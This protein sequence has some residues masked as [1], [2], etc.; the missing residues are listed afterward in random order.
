MIGAALYFVSG[1]IDWKDAQEGVDWGL[2]IF[3]G[4]ALSLGAALL[5]TGAANYII[6]HLIGMMGGKC[7]NTC[8]YALVD[9]NC[10]GFHS[11]NV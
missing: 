1:V 10:S 4:G 6:N 9:D 3:F 8:Y 5:N 7:F 2:I 11:G